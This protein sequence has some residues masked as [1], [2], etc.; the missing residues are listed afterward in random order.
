[1]LIDGTA[2]ALAVWEPESERAR[3]SLGTDAV[4]FEEFGVY[5]E[6][7]N[8]NA[9]ATTLADPVKR[10]QTVAFVR[11]LIQACHEA[12][13]EPARAQQLTAT[14]TG[15][16]LDLIEAAWRHHHFACTLPTDLLDALTGEERWLAAQDGR[17]PRDRAQLARLIDPSILAE[18][19]RD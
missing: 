4:E 2:D 6:L 10:R 1:M 16:D 5:R 12:T 19:Q 17:E 9:T 8:L 15:F 3:Q 11:A 13:Y 14:R 7:Y 18:A